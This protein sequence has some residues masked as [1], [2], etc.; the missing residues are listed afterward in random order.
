MKLWFFYTSFI[1]I[2]FDPVQ[3]AMDKKDDLCQASPLPS[4][5]YNTMHPKEEE[6]KRMSITAVKEQEIFYSPLGEPDLRDL[7]SFAYQISQGMV[8]VAMS[9]N[10]AICS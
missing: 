6:E 5:G 10:K 8:C 4:P 7:P 1:S 3:S 9:S 2:L